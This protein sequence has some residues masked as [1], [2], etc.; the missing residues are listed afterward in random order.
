MTCPPASPQACRVVEISG[1]RP[2]RVKSL[3]EAIGLV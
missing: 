1:G 3:E 2:E